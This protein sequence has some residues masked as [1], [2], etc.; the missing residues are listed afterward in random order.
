MLF[1]GNS[2]LHGHVP[3]VLHY[4]AARVTD[5]NGTGYG[6]VPGLFKQLADDV[7][8]YVDVVSEL[9][10]GQTLQV[11]FND[12]RALIAS[13]P[14][15]IVVLQEYSTLSPQR[16]GDATAFIAAAG[17]LEA[18]V[19]GVNLAARVYLLQTWARADQVYRMPGGR[20]AGKTLEATQGGLHAAYAQAMARASCIAGVLPVGDAAL[21]AVQ[22]GVADR[23]PMTASPPARSMCGATT[24]TTS[25]PGAAIWRRSSSSA[26]SAGAIR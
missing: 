3:P 9:L 15:D 25:A 5:L 19:H 10:S 14:G 8:L 21:W 16:P 23:D 17:R 7:G 2:F 11:H 20:W 1:V 6:G 26:S 22:E 18:A 4:N 12:K 24:A 13:R